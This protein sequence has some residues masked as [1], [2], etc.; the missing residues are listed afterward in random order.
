MTAD[1][2]PRRRRYWPLLVG[3]FFDGT[4]LL[5]ALL[6]RLGGQ[7]R[8]WELEPGADRFLAALAFLQLSLIA[9]QCFVFLRTDIYAVLLT[10]AGCF[11]LWRVNQLL[12]RR[13]L[14]LITPAQRQELDAA[15][16]RDLAV[17]RWY[18]WVYMAGLV[19]AGWFFVCFFAPATV[20]LLCWIAQTVAGAELADPSFWEALVFGAVVLSPQMATLAIAVRDISRRRR[21]R[22]AA[23]PMGRRRVW[24]AVPR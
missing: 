14:R 4:V 20:R 23:G 10:A 2:L 5:G 15:H 6:G 8:W 16:P 13:R 22:A 21:T 24:P 17:A 7:L 11:D 19:L 12:L 3:T 1:G 9:S 18:C